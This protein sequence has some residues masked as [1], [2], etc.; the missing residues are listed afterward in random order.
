VRHSK[1]R[2]FPGAGLDGSE[3]LKRETPSVQGKS[4]LACPDGVVYVV[5]FFRYD[6]TLLTEAPAG[7]HSRNPGSACS[8]S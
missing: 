4:Q 8:T 2:D 7:D 1:R 3:A 5:D 6:M